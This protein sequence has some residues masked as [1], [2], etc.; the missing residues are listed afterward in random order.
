MSFP[1]KSPG[2]WL[3]KGKAR[4]GSFGGDA[5][6]NLAAQE[7]Q[8]FV[9]RIE[10]LDDE[11]RALNSDKSEVFKEVKGAG[12]TAKTL[13]K[14]VAARRMD[15]TERDNADE[16]FELY[17]NAV[18]GIEIDD[19]RAHVENIEE[20]AS[21]EANDDRSCVSVLGGLASSLQQQATREGVS[22]RPLPTTEIHER[23]STNDKA[24]S[25]AGPQAKASLAG[26]GSEMLADRE[27]RHEGQGASVALPTPSS[28]TAFVS[29]P[30]RPYC[31]N[32]GNSCGGQGRK[33]CWTCQKAHDEQQ[34]VA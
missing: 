31:L 25:E 27:A 19:V 14:V 4:S 18:H 16:E 23:A 2:G 13:R 24:S 1:Y 5:V 22:A 17:W 11:I 7:L 10:S 6:S 21:D 8:S 34:G 9:R 26:T 12:F 15:A 28:V 33:H 3:S 32:P 20:F 30:L 29:K